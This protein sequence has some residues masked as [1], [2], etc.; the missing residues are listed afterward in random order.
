MIMKVIKKTKLETVQG[1][2]G[3]VIII[4]SLLA[5]AGW[6]FNIRVLSSI[7]V[8]FIPMAPITACV[9]FLFGLFFVFET[10]FDKEKYK[11][12]L[13][14]FILI[15]TFFCALKFIEYFLHVELT[16]DSLLF[17]TAERLLNFPV[18][19]M[20]PYTGLLLFLSGVA[21]MFRLKISHS[22]STLN[23]VSAIGLVVMF[24]AF[25]ACLGYLFET[26]FLYS[27]RIT[28]LAA[29]TALAFLCLGTAITALAGRKTFPMYYFVGL[30]ANARILKAILP[31]IVLGLLIEGFLNVTFV[32]TFE[33]NSALLLALLTLFMVILTII[34]VIRVSRNVFKRANEAEVE[35]KLAEAELVKFKLG[36][37]RSNEVVFMT[38]IAGNI[39][40]VNPS[41][42]KIY[43]YTKE[44]VL[45]KNPR[46]IQSGRMDISFYHDFWDRLLK[47]QLVINEIENKTKDGSILNIEVSVNPILDESNEI[48]GFLAIQHDITQRKLA[49]LRLLDYSEKLKISNNTKDKLF[50]ILAHDLKSPFNAILGFSEVLIVDYDNYSNE[51]QKVF[52]K[53]IKES[54]ES[55]YILLENLLYWSRSQTGRITA[56]PV[57]LNLFEIVGYQIDILHNIAESKGIRLKNEVPESAIAFADKDMVKTVLLN[58]INN[59]IK[60]TPNGGE[61]IISARDFEGQ[62]EL[63]VTDTGVGISRDNL[64]KLFKMDLFQ[65][66][67]GTSG[68]KGTGLGLMICKEFVEINGGAIRVESELGKGSCFCFTLPQTVPS[69]HQ[70]VTL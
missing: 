60:F 20:S 4:I 24:A 45:G 57:A 18:Y 69:L 29:P 67:I 7:R 22:N 5:I 17:P 53:K 64:E 42:E 10:Y 38:D 46:I 59:A 44:E 11:K 40:Y 3:L 14:V 36:I 1:G 2:A 56:N 50:N 39:L 48:L 54:A 61:I 55:A 37:E 47:K 6:Y 34:I 25:V 30:T 19:R 13:F 32:R 28:P 9:F 66:S 70:P 12:K 27:G 23:I 33:I 31:I 68:E 49:D 63:S 21:I 8:G 35:R 16:F 15:L 52:I 51:Q 26:P 58:L 43:G 65:S 41:F 62:I